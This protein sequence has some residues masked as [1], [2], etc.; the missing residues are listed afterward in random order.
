MHLTV[1][2]QHLIVINSVDSAVALMEKRANKYSDR[3]AFPMLELLVLGFIDI[4][5]LPYKLILNI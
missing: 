4:N 1:F 5:R 3:P 2:G